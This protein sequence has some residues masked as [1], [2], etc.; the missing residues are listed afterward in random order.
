MKRLVM[1][2]AACGGAPA[3]PPEP[4][5]APPRIVVKVEWRAELADEGRVAVKLVVDGHDYASGFLGATTL[6][7]MGP[8]T[9]AIGRADVGGTALVC[10][11]GDRA[12]AELVGEEL[13]VS[14]YTRTE[15]GAG[16]QV[17][18]RIALGGGVALRVAPFV[19]PPTGL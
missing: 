5:I 16:H 10:G 2:V 15:H 6:D 1:L 17:V 13:V 8:S 11:N 4:A 7:A 14:T 9:C 18:Q 3:L 19:A 12:V